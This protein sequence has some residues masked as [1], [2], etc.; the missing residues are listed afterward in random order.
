MSRAT[1]ATRA[2]ALG[3]AGLVLVLALAAGACDSLLEVELPGQV[4]EDATFVPSQA[5]LIANSVI[6][7]VEC[8]LSD[9]TA[10]EAAGFDDTTTRTVGWWGGRFERPPRP[11]TGG[12]CAGAQE[13]S[14][15]LWFTPL[16]KG[17]WMAEQL[18][19]RLENQWDVSQ[20]P[21]REQLMAIAAIYAGI[22]YTYFGE[23]FCEVMA[24]AGPLMTW[25]ESLQ[26]GEQWFTRALGHIGT[27]GDFAIPTGV[28]SS[29]RQMAYLLRA[30]AR[31][32]QNT[33]TKNAE[34]ASDAAQVTQGFTSWV[35]R[36]GGAQRSRFNRVYSSH[37]GLGWVALLGP[38]FWWSGTNP[39]TGQP[40]PSPIP[41]TGYWEL[42]ILP[43]GRAVTDAGSPIT[44]ASAGAVADPRVPA[45]RVTGAG[46]GAG[47]PYNYPRWE[48]RKYTSLDADIPLA[49]WEEAWLIRAQVAG[50][51]T[52]IDLVNQIRAARGLPQVTYLS[53]SDAAGIRNM[54]LEEIRRT[55][56]L[57]HGRWW[58]AKLRYDLWFPRATGVDRWN[59]T[60]QGGVRMIYPAAE[61]TQNTNLTPAAE[62]SGCSGI[63]L[64]RPII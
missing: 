36:E 9:F 57:E 24:N 32:L 61:Y 50:G 38:V 63:P 45:V 55:H 20:V 17:R 2:G 1:K 39:A 11:L 12:G 5:R 43:D 34:A 18:Y 25:T 42:A 31:F 30:R 53:A 33:P 47:G 28:T 14:S 29:A 16:H 35:T 13:N 8:A 54:L 19:S 44:L 6:A 21:D 64:Q 49:K 3:K 62:A 15:G 46:I 48:Q 56:F 37:V 60:Y 23:F 26:L 58:S 40:W 7:D 4:T 51:Q 59:F 52:A 10:F 22:V 27:A 41:Y